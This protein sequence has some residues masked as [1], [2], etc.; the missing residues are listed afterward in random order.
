[1]NPPSIGLVTLGDVPLQRLLGLARIAENEGL[2]TLWIADEAY[3]RGAVPMAAACANVTS[4]LR[5]GLGVVNPYNHTPV[6]MAKDFATLQE[7]AGGRAVLGVGAGWASPLNAQGIPWTRPLAAVRDTV[8]IV[9][10][11]LEGEECSYRGEKFVVR[12][13]KLDFQPPAMRSP[14][15]IAAMFPRALMQ[16]GAIGDGVIL[17]ILCPPAYVTAARSLIEEGAR[18]TGKDLGGFE[19][20][21]Y[22]PMDVDDDGEGARRSGKRYVAFLLRHTYGSGDTR[23]DKVAELGGLDLDEFLR[24]YERLAA[25]DQPEEAVPDALLDRLAIAGTPQH[26]LELMQAYKAAGTTEL[27]AMLPPWCDL[28]KQVTT[29]GRR[30]VPD[31]IRS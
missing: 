23:W 3:F 12:G 22:V 24:V 25:G 7:L 17:S 15:L 16:A 29:I 4:S 8:S 1:M 19:I 9:R 6:W 20:V 31:W 18:S 28:E 5:I 26:C 30:L 14:I 2:S 13:V 27:V 21:Q 11:L 10:T